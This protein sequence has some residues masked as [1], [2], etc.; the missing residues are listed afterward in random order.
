VR[1][2]MDSY[3]ASAFPVEV[4]AC[5]RCRAEVE[6][7]FPGLCPTCV[8]T[9]RTT[10]RSE[11]HVVDAEYVPKVNVTANAVALRDD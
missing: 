11:A 2:V 6:M 7:R 5:P 4:F 1:P 3:D 8:S 10:M 9:L